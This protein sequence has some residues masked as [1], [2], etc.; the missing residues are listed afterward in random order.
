M[1]R[2]NFLQTAAVATTIPICGAPLNKTGQPFKT[3]ALSTEEQEAIAT[4]LGKKGTY[5]EAQATYSIPLP[6]NDLSVTVKGESVPIPFG[7][8]GWVAFKKTLDGKQTVMMS[9]TVLLEAEVNPLIDATHA[10]GL[11]VGAIHNHFFYEQPRIFYMHLHGMGNTAELAQKYAQAI[12]NTKLFPGQAAATVGTSAAQSGNTATPASQNAAP[13]G[14]EL[15]NLPALDELVK[16][17]GVVNGPTYKY[18][19]GRDD[20]QITAMGAEM[21]AAIGLNSWASFAG[22]QEAAHIAGDIAMLEG[23][24]NDVVKALRKNNLEVVALHHHMLGEQP[25][26]V[27][28]HYYGRGPATDL[29]KGF[30]AALDVL[31][32]GK[33]GAMQH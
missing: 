7:F 10:A 22:K 9:D 29:A 25:R 11:E 24:V 4:A 19:V 5:N 2:R 12:R 27:F 32:K 20:V 30:R 33:T 1:K 6:R 31:G 18:T 16:Y 15:F 21:T 3:P 13:T 26:T 8:G 28:L 17:K 23:E 14:K